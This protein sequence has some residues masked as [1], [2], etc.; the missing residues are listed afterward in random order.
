M[1]RIG[2]GWKKLSLWILFRLHDRFCAVEVG[3]CLFGLVTKE[4]RQMF[5]RCATCLSVGFEEC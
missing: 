1:V 5:C 4:E 3:D 2:C